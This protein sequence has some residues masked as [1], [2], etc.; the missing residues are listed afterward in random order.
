[1]NNHKI[2]IFFGI[3]LQVMC[4]CD[5]KSP[6]AEASEHKYQL[7]FHEGRVQDGGVRMFPIETT[8]GT[9]DVWTKTMGRNDQLKVLLL[10][11]GPGISHEY[12]E[13]FES[14][15][16]DAGIEL[17]YYDQLGCGHSENPKDT[18]MWD[19]GRYVDEVE[20]LRIALG[21]DASNFILLGHSWGGILAME[22]A[23]KYQ[24]RLKGL[25]ISNMMC[26]GPEYGRY[27]DEVLALQMEKIVLDSIRQL[28]AANDFAN[29]RYMAL[30][31]KHYYQQHICRLPLNEWP[32]PVN[33]AFAGM[34]SS[35]YVTMQG[36]SEFGISGKLEYWDVCDRLGEIE[37][38]ALVI[39]AKHDTMDPAHMEDMSKKMKKGQ[40]LY[41]P[42]GSHMSFYDDQTVYFDGLIQFLKNLTKEPAQQ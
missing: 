37:L 2:V 11:G 25:V 19:L 41:C 8:K 24:D 29:P 3:I 26:S 33:R 39:G 17:I 16:P 22:Y 13:C 38:P 30:L 4:S 18:S 40:Y 34:N 9:W 7:A 20:Q 21:L 14:F 23:L 12:M 15:L 31:M 5:Q 32:E 6:V 27:A 35:L 42:S 36:P 10:A 28:E 1:M